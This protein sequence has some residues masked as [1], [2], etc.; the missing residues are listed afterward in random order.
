MKNILTS[1]NEQGDI[2]NI[3]VT[4]Y[5]EGVHGDTS[6]TVY[7]PMPSGHTKKEERDKLC[8]RIID[9]T[10][11][12]MLSAINICGPGVPFSA[13]ASVCSLHHHHHH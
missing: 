9:A 12:A 13:I 1:N 2:I 5:K 8:N 3:D 11:K 10:H 6:R 4:V 7:I